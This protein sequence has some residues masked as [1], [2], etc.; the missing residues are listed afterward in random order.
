M[1]KQ[2]LRKMAR[3]FCIDTG[4]WRETLDSFNTA[5]GTAEYS[6]DVPAPYV[7]STVAQVYVHRVLG[8]REAGSTLNSSETRYTISQEGKIKFKDAPTSV[9][10]V[11]PDVVFV[12]IR[13]SVTY[14]DWIITRW[15]DAI[16][17][18]ALFDLKSMSGGKMLVPWYDPGGAEKYEAEYLAGVA[19]AKVENIDGRESGNV[20]IQLLPFV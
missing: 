16:A 1:Q 12:P 2:S 4:V 6:L 5:A 20:T 7:V 3:Q 9:Y 14:I 19:R 11:I 10:A 18:G 13:N 15:G 17:A 8:I